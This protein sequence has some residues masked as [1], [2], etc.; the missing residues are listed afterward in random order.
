[1]DKFGKNNEKLRPARIVTLGCRLNQADSALLTDRLEQL[2]FYL[3]SGHEQ[4]AP[5]LLIVNS[6]AVTAAAAAKSRQ[7]ARKLQK[8]YPAA[9]LIFT[10][11]AAEIDDQYAADESWLKLGN[12]QKRQLGDILLAERA[13]DVIK[14]RAGK[15]ENF[16]EK[17][18][19]LFPNRTRAFIKIQEGCDNFC[20]Y[21]IVPYTR[22]PSRSRDFDE[23]IADCRQAIAAGAPELILTGVNTCNYL[24]HGRDLC[25][26]IREL[27]ENV[28]GPWRLRLSSTEPAP[29]NLS[30]LETMA[31]YPDRVCRFLHLALQHG[32]DS[33]LERMNRH[34]TTSDFENFVNTARKLIPDIHLGSD[35]IVG[36]PGESEAEF[37]R[38]FEFIRKMQFANLHVFS[39]SKRQGTPAATM[40]QQLPDAVKKLRHS[41]LEALGEGMKSDFRNAMRGKTLPVIFETVDRNNVAH[42]WSD[43]YIAVT[44]PAAEVTLGRITNIAFDPDKAQ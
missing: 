27:C 28:P 10:G 6:C 20:S 1:M 2:G 25:A 12:L 15:A 13:P 26:V 33:V 14:S 3:Q 8:L 44:A 37:E 36:F 5:E 29:D 38:S 24:D 35:V 34:Y 9:K 40:P 30:L 17:A 41:R 32:C 42:G 39:Y 11:C 18:F 22:G 4:T 43:N 23:V 7:A 16:A 31:A 19:S 21:C